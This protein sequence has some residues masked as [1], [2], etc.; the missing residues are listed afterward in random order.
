MDILEGEENAV[1]DKA[2]RGL[3]V[4]RNL[5]HILE[6]ADELTMK[7]RTIVHDLADQEELFKMMMKMIHD[8]L[9]EADANKM[10]MTMMTTAQAAEVDE[11]ELR[12]RMKRMLL[13]E[14]Q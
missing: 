11:G 7:M 6:E 3:Q 4:R 12:R 2:A 13:L 9:G 8:L 14:H 10:M 1:R 5:I